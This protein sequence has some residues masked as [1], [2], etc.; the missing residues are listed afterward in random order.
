VAH[1]EVELPPVGDDDVLVRTVYS[2]ISGGTELLAYRGEIDPDLPLDESLGALRG[3]FEFPFLYG[4]SCV[5]R[6]EESRT[7][8]EEGSLVF[9]FH[10]HQQAFVVPA[11]DLV[12]IDGIDPR[13][14]TL[15]PLVE[16][17]LQTTLDAEAREEELVVVVG[18]G[19]VGILTSAL[20]ERSGARVLAV[21]PQRGRRSVA[22]TLGIQSVAPGEAAVAVREGTSG[23]GV[24]LVI[25]A[26]GN[27][28]A[29][30][31]SLDLLAPEGIALVASWYGEKPVPLRLGG[32]FHRRR[33]TIRS[34]QVSS[35]PARLAGQWNVERRRAEAIRLLEELPLQRLATHEYPFTAAAEAFAALDRGAEHMIHVALRYP[36]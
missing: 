15:F 24:S 28:S 2:G 6:V 35:I 9:A 26:S 3:T 12:R 25:E 11:A 20:L 30:D 27:P 32:R 5:G 1:V 36:E 17:A 7:G 29:L 16:T 19:A 14:A 8:L 18:L 22:E 4:Y 33:L 34:T 10:P 21:E 31:E 23:N 13:I